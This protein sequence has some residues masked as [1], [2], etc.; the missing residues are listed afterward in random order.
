MSKYGQPSRTDTGLLSPLSRQ[1][2]LVETPHSLAAPGERWPVVAG[3]P[4]LRT[5]REP[6]VADTLH[7]LDE[8]REDEALALLLGDQDDWAQTPSASLADRLAV[9]RGSMTF[10]EAMDGLAFGGVGTYFAH[11]WSDPTFLSGLALA[12]AHWTCP[13][14][15]FELACGAGHFLREFSRFC[16][17]VSGGD[18]VFAKLW[19]ARRYVAPQARLI[20]FDA[21][22]PWPLADDAA[23]LLFCHD[24]FYF[25]PQ[26]PHVAAEMRRVA[27]GPVLVG[28]AHNALVDNLSSGAPLAPAQYAALFEA[29]TLYDDAVLTGALLGG[30][31][32]RAAAQAELA[33]VAAVSIASRAPRARAVIGGLAMPADGTVVRRNP[34]YQDGLIAWPSPRYQREYGPLASYPD[35]AEGP[36][37]AVAGDRSV[38]RLVRRRVLVDLPAEW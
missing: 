13:A 14:R 30:I 29:P 8:G 22:Q 31:V 7:L 35:R 10:R 2:L 18:V 21:A 16:P 33:G 19:L 9:V 26:K 37:E 23:D 6:L 32:P 36:L 1:K 5:G 15:I 27:A 3:I 34:L 12:E 24:A 38:E 11:R 4:Y 25:L 28:H 17:D 20:C